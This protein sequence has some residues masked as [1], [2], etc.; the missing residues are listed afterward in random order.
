MCSSDLFLSF[1][2]FGVYFATESSRE[3]AARETQ[4]ELLAR[5]GAEL[6]VANCRACHGL[7][8]MGPDEGGIG[9]RLNNIAFLVLDDKNSFGAP[10]TPQGDVTKIHDFIFTTLACG[11]TNTAMPTWSDR[12]GGPMS[13]AP[14]D[15]KKIPPLED[16]A[17]GID[18]AGK[19][20][21]DTL[22]PGNEIGRAH[23]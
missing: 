16:K 17:P 7:E 21:H 15:G 14:A 18:D 8:G 5:R 19:K 3:A 1:L 6:F 23:V 10:A 22:K 13:D 20:V 2:V 9:P 4:S 11:R 12:Y